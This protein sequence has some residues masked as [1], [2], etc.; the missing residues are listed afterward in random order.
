MDVGG[1]L[2][3]CT[4]K[5][6]VD[7]GFTE[8]MDSMRPKDLQDLPPLATNMECAVQGVQLVEGTTGPPDYLTEAELIGLMERHGIGTD[9]SIPVH[10]ANIVE[11]NYVQV[12]GSSR[13]LRPTNLGIVL[14]HGYYRIDPDLC[15]PTMRSAV[16]SQLGLIAG[17]G[18]LHAGAAA[19]KGRAAGKVHVL[20]AQDRVH[21]RAV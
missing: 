7:A 14:I 8:V 6:L 2:F 16:E 9:A 11:R 10:M 15:L 12:L 19:C 13:Q 18:R 1:E 4:G 17:P 3:T 21:G 20:H 5:R